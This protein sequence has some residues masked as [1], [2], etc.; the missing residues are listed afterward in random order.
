MLVEAVGSKRPRGVEPTDRLA[1]LTESLGWGPARGVA[2]AR[3]SAEPVGL[4]NAG[5]FPLL[6]LKAA[7]AERGVQAGCWERRLEGI[8]GVWSE[9]LLGLLLLAAAA[10]GWVVDGR[11]G[12]AAG[13]SRGVWLR[14]ANPCEQPCNHAMRIQT[15][16]SFNQWL[17]VHMRRTHAARIAQPSHHAT[18]L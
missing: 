18:C 4:G 14:L 9:C 8:W 11:A 16:S 7:G 13:T 15:F 10:A 12:L 6:P 17:G 5:M 3:G 2:A 1:L